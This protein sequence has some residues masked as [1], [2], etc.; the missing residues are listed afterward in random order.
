MH[1]SRRFAIEHSYNLFSTEDAF[2]P[3]NTTLLDAI[4][5]RPHFA[6]RCL[7]VVDQGVLDAHSDLEHRIHAW[8]NAHEEQGL[9]LAASPLCLFLGAKLQK[10]ACA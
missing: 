10:M 4:A 6:N 7:V 2:A 3:T 1:M 5:P 9:V 8:F